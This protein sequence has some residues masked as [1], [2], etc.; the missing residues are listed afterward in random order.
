MALELCAVAGQVIAVGPDQG[1]AGIAQIDLLADPGGIDPLQG[2]GSDLRPGSLRECSAGQGVVRGRVVELGERCAQPRQHVRERARLADPQLFARESLGLLY[3]EEAQRGLLAYERRH[4]FV[5]ASFTGREHGG[6]DELVQQGLDQL[7]GIAL[8]V[9]GQAAGVLVLQRDEQSAFTNA[10]VALGTAL[11]TT[12]TH[13]LE[14]QG[15]AARLGSRSARLNGTAVVPGAALGRASML[16][17]LEALRP[18]RLRNAD[19]G[20]RVERAFDDVSTM[21]KKGYRRV[22]DALPPMARGAVT[23]LFFM[24][25]DQRLRSIALEQSRTHGIAKG[26]RQVAREYAVATYSTG[27]TDPLL[28]E[29]AIEAENLCLLLATSAAELPLPNHGEVLVVSERLTAFTALALAATRGAGVVSAAPLRTDSLGVA[30]VR[31]AA[32]PVIGDVA[33][34]FAWVRPD[35]TLLV[36]ADAGLL[37]VNPPATTIA[38]YRHLRESQRPG[39]GD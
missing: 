20:K 26:L 38:R 14:H 6:V 29:R 2:Q 4:T 39:S 32:I 7:A 16:G 36:D 24:L 17:T 18:G 11:A 10:E 37:R 12:F 22:E 21:L 19:P 8:L 9:H 13:T 31:A 15:D 27:E 30:I 34:L 23:S 5:E 3:G 35:D 25:E 28:E 33:G 1:Q